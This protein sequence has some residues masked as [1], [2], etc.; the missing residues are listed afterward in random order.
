MEWMRRIVLILAIG[1][2]FPLSASAKQVTS[3][4]FLNGNVPGQWQVQGISTAEPTE[5]G[6]IIKTDKGGGMHR[7]TDFNHKVDGI[8]IVFTSIEKTE[9]IFRWHE[10]GTPETHMV[11]LPITFR[12]GGKFELEI[13]LTPFEQWD[14]RTDIVGFVF[15]AGTEILIESIDFIDWG[16][17]EN[18]GYAWKTFWKFDKYRAYSINF[19]WGPLFTYNQFA[20]EQLWFNS[21]PRSDS[22]NRLFYAILIFGLI[23]VVVQ[24]WKKKAFQKAVRG[25]FILFLCLWM[26]FDLR[27][28]LEYFSYL[29]HDYV[30]YISVPPTQQAFRERGSFYALMQGIKPHIQERERYI[31]FAPIPYPFSGLI[32]YY[33]YPILPTLP[34]EVESGIDTW[35]VFERAD[36]IVNENRQLVLEDE[37]ISPP[38][39]KIHEFNP[40]SFVFRA[41]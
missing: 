8:R 24:W 19:M 41:D 13:D 6:L 7:A 22:V 9:A 17:F 5:R 31:F 26:I 32:R 28:G 38:G 14:P 30:T 40:G 3:W 29:L 35:V 36:I 18:I 23:I 34:S 25:F 16:L 4:N 10:N 1:V 39:S 2:L 37:I 33:T 15:P 21:P 11:Q 27:M 12:P 20:Y